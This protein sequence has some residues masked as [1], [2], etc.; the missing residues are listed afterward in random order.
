MAFGVSAFELNPQPGHNA[1]RRT[2]KMDPAETPNEGWVGVSEFS[3]L[4]M[5]LYSMCDRGVFT[6]EIQVGFVIGWIS[7][8][9]GG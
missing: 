1:E 6:W 7:L 5:E 9:C 2:L 4:S 8:D 3:L